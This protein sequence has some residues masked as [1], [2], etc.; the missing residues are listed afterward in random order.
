MTAVSNLT[1]AVATLNATVTTL[2][3][4]VTAVHNLIPAVTAALKA[5]NP[6][7][8]AVI[9]A[10]ATIQAINAAVGQQSAQIDSDTGVLNSALP[11]P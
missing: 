2:N 7:D 6:N 11:L 5:A 1:T 10:V 3:A 4:R 9:S 8:P